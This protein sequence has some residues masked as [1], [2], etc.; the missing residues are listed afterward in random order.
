M[1]LKETGW[2]KE[3]TG[4]I[5]LKTVTAAGS[6]VHGN[7]LLLPERWGISRLANKLLAS[8]DGLCSMELASELGQFY[9]YNGISE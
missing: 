2:R 6:C 3:Q 7:K 1:D 4:F 5:C 8:Q 9:R